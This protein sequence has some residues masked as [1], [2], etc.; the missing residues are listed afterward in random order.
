MTLKKT[1]LFEQCEKIGCKMVPFAGWEMPM[2][3]SSLI[4][5]HEEVRKN[6]G[7]FDISHMGI[8][9]LEGKNAKEALQTMVPTDLFRIG[10]GE[11]CYSVFLN[12]NGGIIDDLIIYDLGVNNEDKEQLVLVINAGTTD[13]DRQWLES[14]LKSKNISISDYK[15]GGSLIA[16]QGP[17][18]RKVLEEICNESLLQLP[19]F[20][21]RRIQ[22]KTNQ[23]YPTSSIFIARTGY[24]GEDGFE[25]LLPPNS[26]QSIWETL[27]NK[28]LQPCGLGA[29]D[30]LRLEA[31]M[32][33][34]GNEIN[35]ETTPFEAGL[36]WLVNL[37]MPSD[38][39]GRQALEKQAK[40]GI[41][42]KL[43]GLQMETRAIA[44]KGHKIMKDLEDI[45]HITSGSWSPTLKKAI[46]LAYIPIEFSE[47]G[48]ELQVQ[49]RNKE[50]MATI[51]KKPFY[52]KSKV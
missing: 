33:L 32:H 11:A 43:I 6:A 49:I 7:V 50:E 9:L 35:T 52:K 44:R 31:A 40:E 16:I 26:A 46:A 22:L 34:Y 8:L 28:D 10:E 30:T 20:S 37:E 27:I 13:C 1:P 5:E 47:V 19:R 14:N 38:F 24:T 17:N 29:R 25:C 41:R 42:K 21:H 2:Q 18:S 39:I 3:F 45:G 4:K 36:G 15:Q 51:V 23:D 48:T 12:Q